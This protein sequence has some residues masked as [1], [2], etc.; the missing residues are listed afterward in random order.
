MLLS[1]GWGWKLQPALM[2]TQGNSK[3]PQCDYKPSE[4]MKAQPEGMGYSKPYAATSPIQT[5]PSIPPDL[6]F[7]LH[8][9][10]HLDP[11]LQGPALLL[12]DGAITSKR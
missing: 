1:P 6:T 9:F 2:Q 4:S 3:V 12:F 7:H 10:S 8:P 5:T 11:S